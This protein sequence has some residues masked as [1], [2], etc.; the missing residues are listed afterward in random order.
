M[1]RSTWDELPA[2]V[3]EDVERQVGRVVRVESASAGRN[4]QFAATLHVADTGE[5]LF[6]KG[7]IT[8]HSQARAYRHEADINA[9]LPSVAPRLR[10]RVETS[11]WLMLGFD[12]VDGRHADLSPGS[13]DLPLVA[14][15]VAAL[16]EGLCPSPVSGVPSVV[17]QWER[18]AAW[19]RIRRDPPSDLDP[20]SRANLDR[21]VDCELGAMDL[22]D[23]QC[24]L[25]TDLQSL[26][27]LMAP[28]ARVVDWAWAR[29]GA[30]WMDTGF[31]VLRLIEA[32]HTPRDA[33]HWA[34]SVP[35]WS[36][37]SEAAR[38]VFAIVVLGV[39][40]YLQRKHPLPHRERLT[41]VA[42]QW[43]RYRLAHSG[44]PSQQC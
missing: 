33:E 17:G 23:G 13:A 10:W 41:D 28:R 18:L 24:L 1:I 6:V 43:A 29:L 36:T 27:I 31:L 11:G 16:A 12:H 25:H 30:S 32:G 3:R 37:G 34:D 44:P 8:D 9:W 40:E 39:W 5:Q 22:W 38:T 15:S 4:S 2:P 14:L 20:W 35:V 26:N 42:R 19:R 7:I 21:F